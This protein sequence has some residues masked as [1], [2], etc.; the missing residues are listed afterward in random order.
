MPNPFEGVSDF[1]SEMARMREVGRRGYDLGHE[2]RMRTYA[3]AWVPAT[4]IFAREG[5]LVIR[6]ELAGVHP[7]DV[8]ITFSQGILTVAGQRHTELGAA[9]EDSFCVRERPYGEF[10]RSITLPVGTK[11]SDISAEFE[12]GLAEITAAGG[13]SAAE[14]RR[15]ELRA[16]PSA[17][18]RRRLG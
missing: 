4:D 17:P 15:I 7:E 8:D 2:G 18:D 1:F 10:R 9:G 3:T 16:P 14:P 5:D 12:N 6:V 11:D 13:A